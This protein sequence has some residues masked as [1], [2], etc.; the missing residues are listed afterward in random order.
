[1]SKQLSLAHFLSSKKRTIESK[2][3]VVSSWSGDAQASATA[4]TLFDDPKPVTT[5]QAEDCS[6]AENS[7]I[8][9]HKKMIDREVQVFCKNYIGLFVNKD[10]ISPNEIYEALTNWLIYSSKYKF[11]QVKIYQKMWSVCQHSW[12]STYPW[13]SYSLVLQGVF[14]RYC[15]LCKRKWS[16][17]DRA[18]NPARQL[19]LKQL[20]SL[21]N[22]HDDIQ[23]HEK[24]DYHLFSKE[25]AEKVIVT[26]CNPE[27]VINHTLDK[28]DQQQTIT[29]K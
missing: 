29:D 9:S 24:S 8:N 27:K 22:A 19:I 23:S 25:H 15:V 14:G 11:P 18:R 3:E 28:E 4:P 12:L 1:M 16:S 6:V 5:S 10:Q 26:H 7:K 2:S 17:S 20:T 13:L 21:Y